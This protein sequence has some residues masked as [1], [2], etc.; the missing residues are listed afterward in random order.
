[1]LDVQPCARYESVRACDS[2]ACP[3]RNPH[4]RAQGRITRPRIARRVTKPAALEMHDART[5]CP[6]PLLVARGNHH[7]IAA[8]A[9]RVDPAIQL[10]EPDTQADVDEMHVLLGDRPGAQQVG[11]RD[12]VQDAFRRGTRM[13]AEPDHATRVRPKKPSRAKEECRFAGAGRA[14]DGNH[15]AAPDREINRPQY[16]SG[17]EAPAHAD[18]ESLGQIVKV[19]GGGH[20]DR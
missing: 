5:A 19:E 16:L 12:V 2:A 8:A 6:T 17:R 14:N 1:M 11:A 9:P 7:R 3:L 15:L 20:A 4:A 10:T 18:G 13:I